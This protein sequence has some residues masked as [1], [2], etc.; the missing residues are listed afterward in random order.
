MRTILQTIGSPINVITELITDESDIDFIANKY[1]DKQGWFFVAPIA[2]A[3][4]G[5]LAIWET[6]AQNNTLVAAQDKELSYPWS[7][8]N[9]IVANNDNISITMLDGNG[10]QE[11][12]VTGSSV[13]CCY[14]IIE[15]MRKTI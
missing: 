14:K 7:L 4:D 1:K 9:V 3:Y 13:E 5:S 10:G 8:S 11:L 2:W 15:E 6:I 12:S